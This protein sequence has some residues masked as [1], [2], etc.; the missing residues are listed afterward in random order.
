MLHDIQL[1]ELLLQHVNKSI[2]ISLRIVPNDE[3]FNLDIRTSM[4]LINKLTTDTFH[5]HLIDQLGHGSS[6][7]E[8]LYLLK[9]K[10][11]FKAQR[12]CLLQ[13]L[14]D[15]IIVKWSDFE[16]NLVTSSKLVLD[17]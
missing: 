6:L 17:V 5:G 10:W 15:T 13:F 3:I 2:A 1:T 14:F 8:H 4:L 11:F 16:L 12:P 9:I 7:Q